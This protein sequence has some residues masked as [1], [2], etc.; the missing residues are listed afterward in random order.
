MKFFIKLYSAKTL[1]ILSFAVHLY[2][3]PEL[4]GKLKLSGVYSIL[5]SIWYSFFSSVSQCKVPP[6]QVCLK[7]QHIVTTTIATLLM[8]NCKRPLIVPET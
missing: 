2:I 8:T 3:S 1:L 6:F 4:L 5:L 7:K